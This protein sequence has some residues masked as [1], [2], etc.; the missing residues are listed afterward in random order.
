MIKILPLSIFPQGVLS[1]SVITTVWVGILVVAFFNLRLG[2]VL[3]G[4]VIP[5]YLVPILIVKPV[6]ALVIVIEAI[7]TYFLMWFYSE[8]LSNRGLWS[9]LFGRDRFFALLLFS[10][11]VRLIM[12]G[13]LLPALGSFLN[14]HYSLN[15]DYRNNLHSFGLIIVALIANQFGKIGLFRGLFELIITVGVT[16]IIV[17]FVL[18][19]LTNFHIS[20]LSY[21]YTDIALSMLASPKTY[22]ILIIGAFIASRMNLFYGWEFNGILIPALLTLQWYQPNKILTSFVEAYIILGIAILVLRLPLFTQTSM[23]GARKIILFFNIGF[24]YKIIL[25]Y[26]LIFFLPHVKATDFFAFG[27]LLSTLIAIKMYDKKIISRL[28]FSTIQVSIISIIIASFIGYSLTLFPQV[29]LFHVPFHTSTVQYYEYPQGTKMISV[30]RNDKIA[31]YE[32]EWNRKF[33]PPYPSEIVLFSKAVKILSRLKSTKASPELQQAKELLSQI[34]YDIYILENRYFYLKEREPQNG[35][36]IYVIDTTNAR[37]TAIE[38]PA[39]MDEYGAMDVGTLLYF[40]LKSRYLAVA[41]SPQHINIHSDVLRNARTIYQAFHLTVSRPD[42]LQ[43]RIYTPET[44]KLISEYLQGTKQLN[45]PD[46]NSSLWVK[47]SLPPGLSLATLKDSI[48]KL[49]IEWR[50]SP[51]DNIQRDTTTAGFAELFLNKSDFRN[52]LSQ[53]LFQKQ[54][55]PLLLRDESIEGYLQE[56]ILNSKDIIAASGTNLYIPPKQEEILFFDQQILVPLLNNIAEQYKNNVW[57]QIGLDELK[58]INTNA[59]QVG[60]QLMLYHHKESNRDYLIL[61]EQPHIKPLHYRGLYVFRLGPSNPF[62]IQIPRPLYDVN[63]FE[64]GILLFETLQAKA[65]LIA[66]AHPNANLD[67]SADV[68]SFQNRTNFFNLVSQVIMRESNDTNFMIVQSRTFGIQPDVT[69]PDADI[70]VAFDNGA[71]QAEQLTPLGKLLLANLEQMGLSTMLVGGEPETAGYNVGNI[72]QARY[73]EQSKN[74]EF[75]ILWLSPLSRASFRQQT[76]NKVQ[77]DQFLTAGIATIEDGLYHFLLNKELGYSTDVP[78][79]MKKQLIN[80]LEQQDILLLLAIKTKWPE[81]HFERVLDKNTRNSYLLIS[82]DHKLL[83][84]VNLTGLD[85]KSVIRMPAARVEKET[86]FRFIESRATWLEL[87]KNP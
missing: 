23:E 37:N 11:F 66:G 64:F 63:S 10:I 87:E 61:S 86:V 12:D 39:P 13:W 9:T 24:V 84:I 51:F 85:M 18:A 74:K 42:V 62:I 59:S 3:S 6:S 33:I 50:K 76:E 48:K 20:N 25:G 1:G 32:N 5:G 73:L 38:V 22:I 57:S 44:A 60:Y 29:F 49:D 70:L 17:R 55:I 56:W 15:F 78:I 77:E 21:M 82:K 80:Y 47:S 67:K 2:W 75:T 83:L 40:A 8:F 71:T 26:A 81:Y 14:D 69:I 72:Y 79:E 4:L 34:N 43:I 35:W 46:I 52:I 27:Y 58:I 28:T 30:L 53:H 45:L 65:L 68:L 7:I 19:N 31:L 36:G 41:G 16:Y 54:D